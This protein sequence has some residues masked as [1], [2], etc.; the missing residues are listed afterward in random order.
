M[1]RPLFGDLWDFSD[2]EGTEERMRAALPE[3]EAGGDEG[4]RLELLTQI[5]RTLGLQGRFA[6]SHALLDEVEAGL[7][8]RAVPKV[9]YLLER[10]RALRSGGDP[11]ASLPL[12]MEA[13]DLAREA[14]E[15]FLAVDAAHMAAIVEE[16]EASLEWHERAFGLARSSP[17]EAA[18]SW[19]GS[20]CNN[21]AWTNHDLGRFDRAL[22][23]H[24]E[25]LV[26]Q[27]AQGREGPA[28]I[29]RWAVART[30]RS[31]GRLEEALA[32]QEAL[33]PE[34]EAAGEE[35]GF[36]REEIGEC[37]LALGREEEARPYLRHAHE[38]LSAI[39]WVAEGEPE[40]VARLAEL[41]GG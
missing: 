16:A 24:E 26:W 11:P 20:L 40:R 19:I 22:A 6:E 35:D 30:L 28:R 29:A 25:G 21:L 3:V 27:E 18:G 33:L 12:F 17:D 4:A 8:E 9:R 38:R 1:P 14:R 39:R 2:P 15:D 36:C 31:L 34:V 13:W 7:G 41:A 23:L 5:A 37:L 10:G 32:G